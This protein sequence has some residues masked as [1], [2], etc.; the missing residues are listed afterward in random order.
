MR[1]KIGR[2]ERAYFT[3]CKKFRPSLRL[4]LTNYSEYVS[5]SVNKYFV[6]DCT[7]VVE[8]DG[9]HNGRVE[10]INSDFVIVRRRERIR[11]VI[12]INGSRS[13]LV[14]IFLPLATILRASLHNST[15]LHC[16]SRQLQYS[17]AKG[18]PTR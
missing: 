10:R 14:Y 6:A 5:R 11:A 18:Y 4:A 2:Y 1:A 9:A 7:A 3:L 16:C 8:N 13:Q 15:L 17:L 12:K